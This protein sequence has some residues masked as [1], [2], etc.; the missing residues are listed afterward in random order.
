VALVGK[1]GSGKSTFASLIPRFYEPTGGEILLDGRPLTSYT[2]DCLRRQIA[3]VGQQVTLFNDTL[4]RNIAYGALAEADPARIRQAVARAH[5]DGFI[6][7]LPNGLATLVGDDGVLLSGGQR[8]RV[9]I[10]RA[11]LKDAP[12]LILDEATSAL[13]TESER[14]IQAALEEVMR[15][16]TTIVIA[17]RLSTVENADLI[18]VLEEGRIVESGSHESLLAAGGAYAGLYAAQFKEPGNGE[19]VPPRPRL[20]ARP[21]APSTDSLSALPRAWYSDARWIRSLEPVSRVFRGVADRRRRAYLSGRRSAWRAPVP[22]VV[23]GNIAVGGTGKTPLV[24]WLA[25]WLGARGLRPGIVSR[26]YG[27]RTGRRPLL[28]T[29][30]TDPDLAGDEG[31]LVVRRTGRPLVVCADRVRAVR[32]LLD[33]HRCDVILSDDGL[34]HYALGR[35]V[36]IAV[37]DGALGLGNGLCLPAGPLRE[38]PQRL[39]EVDMVVVNGAALGLREDEGVMR[40]VPRAFVGVGSGE[41][42]SLEAFV[43]AHR[44]VHAVAGI[45]NPG[46]FAQTLEQL[47]LE[48]LLHPHPDHHRFDGSELQFADDLAVVC[49]EKDAVKLSRLARVPGNCWYL[50]VE[51][52]PGPG[53]EERLAAVLAGHGI[54]ASEPTATGGEG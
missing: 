13:D 27:G 19:P 43:G 16:R 50:E 48:P 33:S 29:A 4:E 49:T 8:Q 24:I 23:V 20:P 53:L 26:G 54:L 40:L 21:R 31:P 25:R 32:H 6:D 42:V 36:E 17:H 34:Q 3:L 2:L 47:G 14:H 12:I 22:V 45:G 41:R 5:A 28:V 37:V 51:V 1:S 30:D 11:L 39:A 52:A 10:A 18:L 7:E 15:G 46:R 44:G 38:P 9:A 35:D